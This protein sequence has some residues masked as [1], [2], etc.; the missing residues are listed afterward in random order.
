MSNWVFHFG[1]P[2]YHCELTF[3]EPALGMK[4]NHAQSDKGKMIW[5]ESANIVIEKANGENTNCISQTSPMCSKRAVRLA[6]GGE[7]CSNKNHGVHVISVRLELYIVHISIIEH[8]SIWVLQDL[9][10]IN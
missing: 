4:F 5:K 9:Y 8:D 2:D 10:I 1:I 6:Y 3:T 7:K